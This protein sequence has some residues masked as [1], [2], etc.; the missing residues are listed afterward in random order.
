MAIPAITL[1]G[2]LKDI[3]GVN[4]QNG[5]LLIQLV[6]FGAS[7]PRIVGTGILARTAPL[8][9][10]ADASGAFSTL[11]YGNDVITPDT[12]YTIQVRDDQ[13][14]VVMSNGYKLTIANGAAQVLSDLNT[15]SPST[16][17]VA[18]QT[19]FGALV[20][21]VY[22]AVLAINA[23]LG[24]AFEVT[25]TGNV[26]TNGMVNVQPGTIYTFIIIQDGV[27]GR[28]FVWPGNVIGPEAIGAAANAI[29]VQSFIA[30]GNGNLYPIGPMTIS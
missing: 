27:G 25:L 10:L 1:S 17:V 8:E 2:N 24:T 13:N 28:T 5:S 21:L 3:F 9:I 15:Y 4:V 20:V 30:R 11:I 16:V 22:N 14:N 18:G 29:S 6:G 26:G 7:I 12:Y 19:V 23:A